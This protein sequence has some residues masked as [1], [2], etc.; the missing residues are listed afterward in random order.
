MIPLEGSTRLRIL[1][2]LMVADILDSIVEA[3]FASIA[4]WEG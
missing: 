3:T 2:L 4:H 1:L